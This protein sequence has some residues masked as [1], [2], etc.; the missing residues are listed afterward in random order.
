M[1][2]LRRGPRLSGRPAG[3][4]FTL[5]ELHFEG[6]TGDEATARVVVVDSEGAPHEAASSGDGPVGPG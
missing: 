2:Q 4:G 6:G 5:Q 3:E 1:S